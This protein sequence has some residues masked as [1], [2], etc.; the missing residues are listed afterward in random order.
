[1]S[2]QNDQVIDIRTGRLRKLELL[3]PVDLEPVISALR[4]CRAPLR[5]LLST[6]DEEE[7]RPALEAA[8]PFVES[9]HLFPCRDLRTWRPLPFPRMPLLESLAVT[10]ADAYDEATSTTRPQHLIDDLLAPHAASLRHLVLRCLP[11]PRDEAAKV[12]LADTLRAMPRL[13]SL[14]ILPWDLISSQW[15]SPLPTSLRAM[16]LAITSD[17]VYPPIDDLPRSLRH[18]VLLPVG[19]VN[20]DFGPIVRSLF[21]ALPE[22]ARVDDRRNNVRHD[23]G[24]RPRRLPEIEIHDRGYSGLDP[25]PRRCENCVPDVAPLCGKIETLPGGWDDMV[26][27]PGTLMQKIAY[28]EMLGP[29]VAVYTLSEAGR[30]VMVRSGN[31]PEPEQHPPHPLPLRLIERSDTVS[32]LAKAAQ[33]CARIRK[34][35]IPHSRY[36]GPKVAAAVAEI[37]AAHPELEEVRIRTIEISDEGADILA[38]AIGTLPRLRTLA[39]IFTDKPWS[40]RLTSAV[41]ELN[42]RRRMDERDR[43]RWD[44]VLAGHRP[45]LSRTGLPWHQ[46]S[47]GGRIGEFV[48]QVERVP[49]SVSKDGAHTIRE[50][51]WLV[52]FMPDG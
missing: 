15:L 45:G 26:I 5:L 8:A 44:M 1:M 42:A 12:R 10:L 33:R 52:W 23:K 18:V 46:H 3:V 32:L 48:G 6:H 24:A 47:V 41:R 7:M 40:A 14:V 43:V 39:L 28:G 49:V 11:G 29:E 9:L 30:F 36:I 31:D 35:G 22:L 4:E 37:I 20:G 34:F 38:R 19:A 13:E 16:T 27:T 21:D 51:G 17:G 2:L 25:S 50:D